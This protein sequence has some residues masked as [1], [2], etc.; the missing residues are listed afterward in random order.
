M[1]DILLFI[2]LS[3]TVPKRVSVTD[4]CQIFFT[5][6]LFQNFSRVFAVSDNTLYPRSMHDEVL[7]GVGMV[8]PIHPPLYQTNRSCWYELPEALS[9]PAPHS[10]LGQP[11]KHAIAAL[12]PALVGSQRLLHQR[13]GSGVN[14]LEGPFQHAEPAVPARPKSMRSRRGIPSKV[15]PSDEG[16]LRIIMLPFYLFCGQRWELETIVDTLAR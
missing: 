4:V 2:D 10:N 3:Y 7:V 8:V 12:A 13:L 11:L 6:R 9:L 1:Y 16:G 5:W 14:G 15:V